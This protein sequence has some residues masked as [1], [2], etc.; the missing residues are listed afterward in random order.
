MKKFIYIFLITILLVGCSNNQNSDFW[1][2]TIT[3]LE[4][5]TTNEAWEIGLQDTSL[6]EDKE[7]R[8]VR[9]TRNDSNNNRITYALQNNTE[10]YIT[11]IY[12]TT[13]R[14]SQPT[15]TE[16]TKHTITIQSTDALYKNYSIFYSA[17]IYHDNAYFDTKT[18]KG[19]IKI[20][21]ESDVIYDNVPY[22]K[23][24]VEAIDLMLNDFQND[25]KI[26]YSQSDFVPVIQYLKKANIPTYEK[27]MNT[28]FLEYYSEERISA[29]GYRMVTFIRVDESMNSMQ[30][31]EYCYEQAAY[32]FNYNVSLE[33][34]NIDKLYNMLLNDPEN[35]L[36]VYIDE[37]K[38]Y[39]YSQTLSDTDIYNDIYSNNANKASL[40]LYQE[41]SKF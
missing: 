33:K 21:N 6:V 29:K 16:I 24:C 30:Y 34:R 31:G 5:N 7:H 22:L 27:S 38:S 37:D 25:Y 10:K 20:V 14:I 9:I 23:E 15:Y 13:S 3:A 4:N 26:D 28:S 35:P 36:A 39:F 11:Y 8:S 40:I 19:Y 18:L 1:A 12:E 41:N 2:S 32:T 17:Q